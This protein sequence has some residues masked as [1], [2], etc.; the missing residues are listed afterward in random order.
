MAIDVEKLNG[1]PVEGNGGR[2]GLNAAAVE[3]LTNAEYAELREVFGGEGGELPSYWHRNPDGQQAIYG[4]CGKSGEWSLDCRDCEDD[5]DVCVLEDEPDYNYM[6]RKASVSSAVRVTLRIVGLAQR[7]RTREVRGLPVNL[8]SVAEMIAGGAD[9]GLVSKRILQTLVESGE[10]ER[11][12]DKWASEEIE[13]GEMT[14]LEGCSPEALNN[15]FH[16]TL[17]PPGVWA[18]RRARWEAIG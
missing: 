15:A 14:L 13:A 9:E 7:A 6:R 17:A 11:H 1:L 4:W 18:E 5:E 8:P 10:L 3:P 16:M 2:G 12:V